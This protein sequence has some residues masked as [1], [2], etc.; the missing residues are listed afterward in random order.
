MASNNYNNCDYDMYSIQYNI[1]C[2]LFIDCRYDVVPRACVQGD[3]LREASL[4][5]FSSRHSVR[6]SS[7]YLQSADDCNN[8]DSIMFRKIHIIILQ[9][10]H[11]VSVRF[12]SWKD[13]HSMKNVELYGMVK[14]HRKHVLTILTK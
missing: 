4:N 13:A 10:F 5:V 7:A 12:S 2:I 3:L 1:V 9:C 8:T 11:T 6:R 14:K